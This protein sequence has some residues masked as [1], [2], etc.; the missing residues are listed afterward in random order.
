MSAKDFARKALAP[1]PLPTIQLELEKWSGALPQP[2]YTSAEDVIGVHDVNDLASFVN[3]LEQRGRIDDDGNGIVQ[4]LDCTPGRLTKPYRLERFTSASFLEARKGEWQHTRMQQRMVS[5][6]AFSSAH[7]LE[8][9]YWQVPEGFFGD[10]V[11]TPAKDG[12]WHG[13]FEVPRAAELDAQ[14]T[15]GCDWM[16]ANG[17]EAVVPDDPEEVVMVRLEN[18]GLHTAV[19]RPMGNADRWVGQYHNGKEYIIDNVFSWRWL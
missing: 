17:D 2:L 4:T 6:S 14:M 7:N 5:S 3:W 18:G 19:F 16:P 12:E 8:G 9:W 1:L 13:P 15:L 10:M 11:C